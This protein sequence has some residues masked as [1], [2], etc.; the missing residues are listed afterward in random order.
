LSCR[1]ATGYPG[2]HVAPFEILVV[3]GW[4]RAELGST[5]PGSRR[6]GS[7]GFCSC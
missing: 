2:S 7:R 1:P 6:S 3:G 4:R 5:W